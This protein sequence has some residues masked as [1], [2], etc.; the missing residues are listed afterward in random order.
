[1]IPRVREQTAAMLPSDFSFLGNIVTYLLVTP[2]ITIVFLWQGHEIFHRLMYM[3]PNRYFEMT[4][5]LVNN[6]YSNIIAH[7]RGLSIQF[8][9]LA[10]VFSAGFYLIGLPYW[11]VIGI[12]AAVANIIPY[13]GPAL[14][15]ALA[16][17]VALLQPGGDLIVP[18]LAVVGVAQLVDNALIQPVILARSVELHPLIA[19][20]AV[21]TMQQYLGVIGMVI[22]IP[23]ASIVMV[24]IEIMYRQL[25]AFGII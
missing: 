14:G 18:A 13:L 5:L 4:I 20:M 1:M 3:I 10:T 12:L 24:S 15:A 23:L 21:I 22:A 19:L 17:G 25:K 2:I 16:A 8:A 11:P 6:I 9:I 7:I